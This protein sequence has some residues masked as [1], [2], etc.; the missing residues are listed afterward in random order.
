[1][2]QGNTRRARLLL[3]IAGI[4]NALMFF[5]I[6]C[7]AAAFNSGIGLVMLL[8]LGFGLVFTVDASSQ[9]LW[10][11]M[12]MERIWKA[13][14]GGL[15][16]SGEARSYRFGLIG[17]FVLGDTKTIYPKLREVHGTYEAWTGIVTP[18]AGQTIEEYN[19][20]TK[21]FALA[22]TVRFVSFE[23]T[24]R[25]WFGCVVGRYKCRSNV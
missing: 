10:F 14:C 20:H 19:E 13:V 21:A 23:R 2:Q 25:D 15:D 18:F 16:F 11:E 22:F 8:P 5:L 6:C 24:E 4:T 12:K 3:R 1:M 17:A 9:G 7:E